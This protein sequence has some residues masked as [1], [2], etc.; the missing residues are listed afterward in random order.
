MTALNE[1]AIRELAILTV[2]EMSAADRLAVEAGIRSLTL[3]ETAGGVV[4]A[5]ITARFPPQPVAILCGPGNNGG[6]GYVIA[7]HLHEIGWPVRVCQLPGEMS[8]DAAANNAERWRALNGIVVPF[9][10]AGLDGASLIVD[11][12]FGAG[13]SRPLGPE[14][15]A[16]VRAINQANLPCVAVDVPS[17]VFGDS[18]E[19]L[20][21]GDED[22]AP[23]CVA[24]VT[25]FR[26]KPAH[27]LYPGRALCGHL[28]VADIGIPPRVLETIRPQ[29]WHNTPLMWH[30]PQPSWSDHKYTRGHALV[31]GGGAVTGAAR[32]AARAARRVGAGLLTLAVPE[33]AVPIY[34]ASEPGCLILKRPDNDLAAAL[35]D[36]RRNALLLGPGLGIGAATRHMVSQ[37]LASGRSTVLDA[38][39]LT[40]FAEAPAE[41]FKQIRA[42]SAPTVLTPHGGEFARLFGSGTGGKLVNARRAAELS[43]ATVIFKGPDTVVAQPDGRAAIATNAPPWLATGGSGDVLAGLVLGLL[44]QGRDADTAANAAVWLLGAAAEALGRGLVAEDLPEALPGVLASI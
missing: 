6:D 23:R 14:V 7:R 1:L 28:T 18:G 27:L 16:V 24:T 29:A 15:R 34:A 38:D 22:G 39:A 44:A 26:P 37:V 11:A 36:E 25:F 5:A 12:L 42:R 9:G 41:L 33:A 10:L 13:L 20:G 21:G 8:P 4:T 19:I 30:L 40:S 35:A 3:M 31:V 17:G 32:L 2:A 43:G